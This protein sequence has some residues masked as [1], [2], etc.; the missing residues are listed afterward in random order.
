MSE[1][2]Y[3][4]T[5]EE[6]N[7]YIISFKEYQSSLIPDLSIP[8]FD[9]ALTEKVIKQTNNLKTLFIFSDYVERFL[10]DHNAIL[11][12]YCDDAEIS[13]RNKEVTPQEFRHN[14]FN[15]LFDRKVNDNVVRETVILTDEDGLT[16]YITIFSNK[17][18]EAELD[19]V[20]KHLS[21]LDK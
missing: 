19:R 20:L 17:K 15:S 8:L 4:I 6:G 21:G 12:Y 7:E 1:F 11:Y 5:T 18:N 14:L 13:K 16:H 2:S 10:H 3:N 9:V